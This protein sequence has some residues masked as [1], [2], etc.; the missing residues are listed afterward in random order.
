M[1]FVSATGRGVVGECRIQQPKRPASESAWLA[2]RGQASAFRSTIRFFGW[3]RT[4]RNPLL[5]CQTGLQNC[6]RTTWIRLGIKKLEHG[7]I[8][9][10]DKIRIYHIVHMDRLTSIMD[11]GFL[12]SDAEIRE[13]AC[14]GTTIGMQN[15]KNRRLSLPLRS[16]PE[17]M[18]GS[19]VPFYFCPRSVMLY[20][21]HRGE[22]SELAYRGGQEPIVHLVADVRESAD[23][24]ERNRLRWAFTLTNAGSRYF[25][26][27]SSLSEL[28][29]INWSAV[30]AK[31]WNDSE[32]KGAKQAE[33]LVEQRFPWCLV[34]GIGVHN[35]MV[36]RHVSQMINRRRDHKP[37]V[38]VLKRWYYQ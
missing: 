14:S 38:K 27:R 20:V 29:Q 28:N 4:T 18:V 1:L 26:D 24:A 2:R 30:N 23:W 33:F 21:L 34:I 15:I 8:A 9:T 19:C 11:D 36:F 16:H 25:E 37:K 32:I 7:S 5:T 13:K 3:N 17:L 12:W 10:L 35:E 6:L 31:Q 22:H